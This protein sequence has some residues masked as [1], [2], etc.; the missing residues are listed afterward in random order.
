MVK[1]LTVLLFQMTTTA[2]EVLKA[3]TLWLTGILLTRCS[4]PSPFSLPGSHFSL[5]P[6]PILSSSSGPL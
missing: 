1:L 3:A 2:S 5:K 4:P 6:T